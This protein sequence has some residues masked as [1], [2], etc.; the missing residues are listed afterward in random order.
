MSLGVSPA[1]FLVWALGN[2]V[3]RVSDPI[4]FSQVLPNESEVKHEDGVAGYIRTLHPEVGVLYEWYGKG[5]SL[6]S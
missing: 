3:S 4:C 1:W 5:R 6:S 2:I